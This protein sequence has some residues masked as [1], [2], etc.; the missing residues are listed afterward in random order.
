M[1]VYN[2]NMKAERVFEERLTDELGNTVEMTVWS[3]PPTEDKPYGAKYSL[4]YIVD[5]VRI[6]GYDNAEGKG[7]HKHYGSKEM[8]Y[9]FTTVWELIRAFN[10]DIER[11]KKG[12]QL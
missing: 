12:E 7:D 3:V 2:T 5:G 4:V 10:G 6:I 11:F 1:L 8:S 9:K